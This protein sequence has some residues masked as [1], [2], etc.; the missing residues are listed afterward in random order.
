LGWLG[1]SFGLGVRVQGCGCKGFPAASEGSSWLGPAN[2][3]IGRN[4]LIFWSCEGC[5]LR[6]KVT[7]TVQ[8]KLVMP[9]PN[10]CGRNR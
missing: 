4:T 5:G 7:Q 1:F 6:T 3:K 10:D 8:H 2:S 9:H